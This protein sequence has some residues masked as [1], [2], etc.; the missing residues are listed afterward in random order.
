MTGVAIS[1][2]GVSKKFR[3]WTERPSSL[4]SS[5]VQWSQGKRPHAAWHEFW[6]LEEVSLNVRPGEFIGILG[7]NGSGKS[8]LLKMIAGIYQPTQGRIVTHGR[9]APLIELGAG[10]HPELSGYE[11]IFLVASILG[12][13]RK[14]TMQAV[15]SILAFAE[16][17]ERV[18][19]PIRKF[20]TGMLVRLGF[21]I[22]THIDAPILLVDEVLAVGD[23][24]FQ[25]KCIRRIC[26]LR[27]QG[28]AVI[29]VTHDTE[30]VLKYCERACV[31]NERRVVFDGDPTQAV[32][33]YREAVSSNGNVASNA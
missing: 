6:A 21:S 5:L 11:N 25:S 18:H 24:A 28:R 32:R 16:L 7:R 33:V 31:I 23:E 3:Y 30:A 15:D 10:F 8:T 14:E 1:V 22:A 12:L 4:K 20:S 9:I 27:D 26:E 2:E 17:G 29:L 13:G 19:M